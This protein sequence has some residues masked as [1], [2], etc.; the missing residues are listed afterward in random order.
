M[1]GR[2]N[3]GNGYPQRFEE[4]V[5]AMPADGRA[6]DCGGGDR[7]HGDPR[8]IN[9][10]MTA[11]PT[12]DVVGT[13]LDLPFDDG[14]FDVILS[15]AVLE[16][17]TDPALAVAEMARVLKPG[18]TVYIE[19]AFMQPGHL[20][21]HHYFNICPAGLHL[22]CKPHLDIVGEG[23]FNDLDFTFDW[24]LRASGQPVTSKARAFLEEIRGRRSPHL[25]LV[26]SAVWLEGRKP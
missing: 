16:H 13:V 10:E 17:V 7:H 3:R 15:Q 23:V 22:L 2:I 11:W 20:I 19:A 12:V 26:A 14:T 6:M 21:P 4:L 24:M 1:S 8:V 25:E 9:L 5:A 18:G